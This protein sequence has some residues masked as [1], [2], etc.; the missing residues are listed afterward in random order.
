MPGSFGLTLNNSEAI[1]RIVRGQAL[2]AGLPDDRLPEVKLADEFTPAAYND[3]ALT[4]RLVSVFRSW[5]G[6]ANVVPRPPTMG[7]EDF[8]EY[9]RTEAKIPCCM[10]VVGGVSP[11]AITATE[12]SHQPL[13]SLHS[14][15]WAPVPEPTIKAGVTAMTAAVLDLMGK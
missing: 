15:L 5:F 12:Q 11:A 14:P 8:S 7:G 3:P 10:F 6:E 9:G 13:P 1:K 4:K 2:S